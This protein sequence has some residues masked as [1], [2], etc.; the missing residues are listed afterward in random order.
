MLRL[1]RPVHL[2]RWVRALVLAL[3]MTLLV[4]S[5]EA[6]AAPPRLAEAPK[7]I[8][9]R[10]VGL[11]PSPQP[12][13]IAPQAPSKAD[14]AAQS[15]LDGGA[16]T[17]FDP[18]RS[19]PVS[20]SMFTTEYVNPDGTHSVRQSNQPLNVQDEKG[21]WQPVQTTLETDPATKRADA[22]NH[23]LSPS[24]ATKANDAAVLQVESGGHTAGLALDQAAPT[25]AA[26]KGDSVTYPEV[27]AGTDLDYEVTP[28][29]V[30]ET[31]K[32]KRPPADGR[33]SWKFK[34]TTGDLT[35]KLEKNGAVTLADQAGA[36]KIVL[37]PIET[38]DSAGNGETAPAMTGGTYTLDKAGAAWWLTVAVD[39]NWLRDPK[40][41]YPVSVDPTFTYGVTESHSYRSDGTGCDACGLR[42]GNSQANGDTY[43]RSVFH[44]D[45]SPLFGKTV[46]GARMDL[47]RN[48][49]VVGSL[50]TWNANLYH[51]SAFN[52]NGVGGYMTSALVGD[53]GSF[54]GE[55]MTGFI[56]DR[57]NARDGSVFFMMIG[58]ENAGTWTYK[59]LN[60]TL[61]VD[62]GS[63]AP[64]A[65]LVA[66]AD[67]TVSTSL[68]PT[69]SVNP[70]TDPDGEAVKYCFRIATGADAKSGVVVE[71]GCLTTPT[72]TVPAGI[73]QDGVAYTWQAMTYSGATTIT[74]TWIGHLKIDQRIGDHGPS[75]V[76]D[77]GPVSVNLANGNVTTSQS[78]PTFTTVAGNAGLT[79]T[80]NSQQA[81]NKGLKASYFVDLSHNGIINDAQQPVLVR[82]EPQVNVDWGT[83]SPFAPALPA[84]WFVA[85][86]EGFFQA[87]VA[88]TYQ[89]AGVHDDGGTVW[90]NGAKVYE[91][92][93]ASDLNW[94]Q[95]TGVSLTAGQRVPIKVE[96][97]E[98]TGAAKMR[99]FVRTSDSTTVAPQIVPADWLFTSDLPVLPQGW[100][101]SA[102]LDG[103]G[104]SYTEAKVT[105]QNVV[106]TDATGAKH[107]WTKKSVGGYAP[108]A[109][110]D[111]VLGVDA[112]GKVTLT[113]SGD[114]F[115]FRAD[116]KLESQSS[117]ADA[118]KPA[119]LQYIYDGVPSRLREIKDP[120]SQRSQVLHYN[121]AG[122]DCYGGATPPSGAQAL[123]PSQ[124]LC[125][126]SYWDDTETRLWYVGGN[127]FGRIEDPGSE[128]T[129]YGY[130][131]QGL[132]TGMRDSVANDWI[133]ADPG[134]RKASEGDL[135]HTVGYD[136]TAKPKATSVVSAVPAL[137]QARPSRAY[138]YDP[139]NR[140][141]FTDIAGL[142]PAAGFF[143]KVTYDDAD[144]TTSTTDA[145]GRT[146][147]QEWSPKDLALSTTDPAGRKSTTVYDYADRPVDSYGPA[148]ASCFSGQLPSGSCPG[149]MSHGHSGYD[150]GINGLAVSW[151]GN[152]QLSGL[153]KTYSTGLGTA[154]G[155]FVKNWNTDA[156]N[157]A[158]P[159][160]HFGLRASGDI[161]F[162]AAG[163]YTLRVLADDGVRVWVDD[164]I[165]IDDW[166]NT[167]PAWRQGV[168]HSDSAGQAKR[169]RV[170][171]Y[172]FDLTAQLELH[173]TT[174]TGVQQPVP[175]TQLKPRY[176]LKTSTTA[177]ESGGVSDKNA[178]TRFGEN[179]LDPAYGLATSGQAAPS[180]ANITGAVS[181][182]PPGT[183][184]LRKTAKTKATGAK[185]GYS[186]Y[187]DT[188]SR[189][190]PCAP[191]TAALNQGG[192]PKLTTSPAPASGPARVDEQVYDAS[193]R[194]VAEST[195]GAWTCTVYDARD[196]PL[197]ETVPASADAPARTVTH[198][199]AVGGDP[200]TSS[201][202]DENGTVTTTVD[203]LGRVV[204]YTDVN[205]VR[206]TTAYD[207]AGRTL[208][209]TLTPPS[210]ADAA[211]T[212]SFGYDD[213]GRVTTEK[214]DGVVLATV[215]FDGAGELSS[216][217]YGNGTAL[218]SIT[219]DNAARL[220]ALGWRTADGKDVV[221]QV[222]RTAAGTVTD[223]SLGGV[224]ARPDGSNYGYDTAGRLTEAYVTGHHYTY[225]FTS[226]ASATCPT[227]TQADAGLNTNRMRLLD[228]TAAGT[229][230]TRY[231]YDAADR[232]LATEGATVLSEFAYDTDGNTTS[233]KAVDGTTTALRWDG[234]D[235]NIGVSTR[236]PVPALVADVS[237]TRDATNR[238]TRRD[239]RDCDNNT[240]VRYGFTGDGDT[241]DLTLSADSR[242]T[243]VSLSLP[244]GVHFTA[245]GASASS[246]DHPS[247]RGDLVM[248]TDASGHRVGELRTFDPFGQPLRSN[249]A[250][251]SQ[252]VPDNSP[253]SLDYGWLGQYQRGYE[254]AGGLSIVQMG[255]RPYSPLLGRF[256]SVDPVDGGSAND[257]D[258]TAG[259][260]V[261]AMD[262]DGNSWFSSIV[263][264]VTK[265]AEVV[266]WVPGPIGAVASG[267]AAV[268]NVIQG[269]WAAAAQF[270]AS[271][272]T[273][274]A[275]KYI[276]A[277]VA[278]VG[279]AAKIGFKAAKIVR[280]AAA[281]KGMAGG[282][283]AW[284]VTSRIAGR[285]WVGRGATRVGPGGKFLLSK[286]KLRQYRPPSYKKKLG[287]YQ[288]NFQ[289]R[290]TDKGKWKNNYHV[291]HRRWW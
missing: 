229:A 6:I 281:S 50:K 174:P 154:D 257:Y 241:P 46:V 267:V 106:L 238:I 207:Q 72:W 13:P 77:A 222:T 175:G 143:S 287:K 23:P 31:I 75:P 171:Y 259:D 115:V 275:T 217:T 21:Q 274:G 89:F 108:P 191:G 196:R 120:V 28:G 39:P 223:E 262:L 68:T 86:W 215:G 4:G 119:A 37:P 253:G 11:L 219:K 282:I 177:S 103:E 255:A 110:E 209:S 49:S 136:T 84:D 290:A 97:A 70:V 142:N 254:H 286:N 194:V 276:A 83:D 247:V 208:S 211:R 114:V 124:M 63:P 214:L 190:N 100:T 243:S 146:T 3:T 251:D 109:D 2:V 128:I 189:V 92:N 113:D 218:T 269:N 252:N 152:D 88:G 52:F 216:V 61:T 192:L 212:I 5:T 284:R 99:L 25:A 34:L 197:R 202:S 85:R 256:L 58:A 104:S 264:A 187:G 270:A 158:V 245:M 185:T 54:V 164:Q 279:F 272:L 239:P 230:E 38:W 73:L 147:S 168:V 169:I 248:T 59:N 125:R 206:T 62:T 127:Q 140:Q 265:V 180:G 195:G 224:D 81:E 283:R 184:Y 94:T 93:S 278:A 111:G 78:L 133:A 101:L 41:V 260:P 181:Y 193:G 36:A 7:P 179:G 57:V 139:A 56:R 116:G 76:D 65:T 71:S 16:G 250:V 144:R 226:P 42:I 126:I 242:L 123:P 91:V 263:S 30:K 19:T 227:G 166:R 182:E 200:L 53:V 45:Y 55:G 141:T 130:N 235:R 163:D 240:V 44:M 183:G 273:A 225:D 90:I 27:A 244:G 258:Y 132:L 188:E 129:D 186:Y 246:Y 271:A 150:E 122:D 167:T 228:Q 43:N 17:H 159:A 288:S 74:P 66:P 162:P 87:P 12:A 155:T 14:F 138:R 170:D 291:D 26:V 60:A 157:A 24:L 153:P 205:G 220:L 210:T 173:W 134:N 233:W 20:R 121:R 107:T 149:G 102:D 51:A 69:L 199:Y 232:L 9:P 234:S 117:S 80:Y 118:R 135:T 176:G 261:N 35:P 268:G 145:A 289:W 67:G 22:D 148:P 18:Q 151:F 165:V 15:R 237:Y 201:I 10:D 1:S 236:G 266:S 64:A 47:T 105:D 213:A 95:T 277:G 131:A 33:S 172:E 112:G 280:T 48:T 178:V 98:A 29:A 285:V 82:P 204:A 137:G 79:L 156:P 203:L 198:D 161:V 8:D 221:S 32:L 160:D 40:R 96:N 249:G 231:C